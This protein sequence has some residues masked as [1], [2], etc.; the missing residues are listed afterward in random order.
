MWARGRFSS[1]IALPHLIAVGAA[2]V[3]LTVASYR[4]IFLDWFDPHRCRALMND[5]Q[6]MDDRFQSWQPDGCM[7][8]Q[9]TPNDISQCLSSRQVVFV[10]DSV[11]RQLFFQATHAADETLPSGPSND[12]QKHMDY[13]YK[14]VS[15]TE[16]TFI[17]DPFLNTTGTKDII[18]PS[19][20]RQSMSTT[21]SVR[22]PAMVVIGAGLWFLRHP[23]SG[24]LAL[25]EKTIENMMA[26]IFESP[27]EIADM[28]VLLPV[29][30]VIPDK[31]SSE[32]R[33]WL[34]N[35]D[36]EAMN[37]DMESRIHDFLEVYRDKRRYPGVAFPSVFNKMLDTSQTTDGLHYSPNLVAA[38]GNILFNLRCND[39][40]PK[41]YPLDKTCCR[42]YPR[43]SVYQLFILLGIA[44][45]GP[46]AYFFSTSSR[47]PR[48]RSMLPSHENIKALSIFGSSILLIYLSDRTSIFLKVSKQYNSWAFGIWAVSSLALGLYTLQKG[49][50]DLGFLSRQQT[51]E[52]KGWMQVVI[53]IYHYLGASKVSGI[54]NPVRVLVAAYLFMTGYGHTT[55]YLKKADFGIHRVAQVLVRLNL[56]PIALAYTMNTDYL[57]YY[58]SPLVSMWFIVIYLTMAIAKQFNERT[59]ILLLKIFLSMASITFLL[60]DKLPLQLLFTVLN[61]IFR[62]K[63]SAD[64]WNFRVTLDL[65]IVYCGMLTAVAY[66]KIR[67]HRLMDHPRWPL[68]QRLSIILSAVIMIWFFIFELLQPSKFA[69]NKWHPY[70]SILPVGAFVVLRNAT[71][72]LRSV[73][74][75]LFTFIG[76]CSLET[77]II[78]YHLWLAADTKGILQIIPGSKWRF[79]NLLLSSIIF[80][81]I[82]HL[83]AN[84]TN[85]LTVWICN[86]DEPPSLPVR[87]TSS[88]EES[89]PLVESSGHASTQNVH[90]T[91]GFRMISN[92]SFLSFDWSHGVVIRC[93]LAL[94]V[95]WLLNLLW[96][97][98]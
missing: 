79:P 77:F 66:L 15:G 35:P 88:G 85:Q 89:I 56:L 8:H 37:A 71:P 55:F 31:L 19:L 68:V 33:L 26:S 61:N 7:L 38:H 2:I 75:R 25:W 65:W 49:D 40:L 14:S 96:P 24:G 10:G 6:W 32:R 18:S 84:A 82:S 47:Q 64:E 74:S 93:L 67:E 13:Q 91:P 70:I 1:D 69:Y 11:T 78:Q 94:S 48:V 39:I 42:S 50:K 41:N 60:G 59:P 81:W 29:Q 57:N 97:Y 30:N 73:Y 20:R 5:G 92:N 12:S 22:T 52:W 76:V 23:S 3:S 17:W 45:W 28:V 46:I 58:F 86:K 9:Y 16:F 53:L 21:S 95:M 4:Y 98:S 63:W 44:M 34:M 80:I 72:F 83:V 90:E 51:D 87:N 27:S 43:P 62:L 36:I 54:Y